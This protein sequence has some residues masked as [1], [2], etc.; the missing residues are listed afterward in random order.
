MA[1]STTTKGFIILFTRILRGIKARTIHKFHPLTPLI[2]ARDRNLFQ[3]NIF[4]NLN[5]AC[6]RS[7]VA[8]DPRCACPNLKPGHLSVTHCPM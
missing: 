7:Q 1:A 8:G 5:G 3:G 6:P 2:Q 4:L